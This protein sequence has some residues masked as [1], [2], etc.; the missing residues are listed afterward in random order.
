MRSIELRDVFTARRRIAGV[1]RQT[2]LVYSPGLSARSGAMVYLKLETQQVS[3]AFKVRGA[4]NRLLQMTPEERGRGVITVS[5]GNH[6]RAISHVARSLGM[7]AVVCVPELVLPH[8]VAAMRSL[9][10]EVRVVGASQ[11][12][13]EAAA[14]E[15][16]AADGLTLVSPFDDPA[17]IAGQGTIALEILEELPEVDVVVVPLSGGGLLGG[18]GLVL[19]AASRAIRTV[20]VSMAR[21]PVMVESLH[22]GRPV[23]LAE[24]KSLADS[25]TGGIGLENRYTFGLIQ[26]VVDET[27]LLS[28]D[29]IAAAMVY[30]LKEEHLVVEG[31][32]SVALGAILYDKVSVAGQTVVAVVSGGN[33]DMGLLARLLAAD[34]D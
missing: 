29:E 20:G 24:E 9:G 22:A 15:M 26:Q 32:G 31:G 19:K 23:Q 13:A 8:K 4:A 3:G 33:V 34:A 14:L 17:I 16:A 1:I 12:E 6:G 5:T 25:L 21:G 18:I 7:R 27:A 2:E 10:A 28:E 11:D 30:A